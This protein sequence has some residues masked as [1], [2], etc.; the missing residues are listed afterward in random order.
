MPGRRRAVEALPGGLFAAMVL[1]IAAAAKGHPT[2]VTGV[3]AF[4]SETDTEAGKA[5]R[6][7]RTW[8]GIWVFTNAYHCLARMENGRRGLSRE[9][10]AKLS[11]DE[12]RRYFE[13]LGHFSSTAGMYSVTGPILRRRWLVAV[14]PELIG[15]E[16]V[17]TYAIAGD[18]LTVDLPRRS[19]ESGPSAR[20]VYRRVEGPDERPTP[21]TGVW[22]FV[23]ES[24]AATGTLRYDDM[25][26]DAIWIFTARHHCVARMQRNRQALSRADL[27]KLPAPEQVKYYEQL[28]RYAST[29]GEYTV[30]GRTLRRTWR[31]A[32]SPDLVGRESVATYRVDG[33]RL[34]VNLPSR[35]PAS[36]PE[37]RL[38]YR[39]LE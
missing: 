28:L 25:T 17:G 9:E 10:L 27:A 35:S 34:V 5:I 31:V 4:V 14:G 29:A 18:R 36:G 12:Q 6:D 23:S 3:W 19:P 13:Q 11:P 21:V 7:D 37:V 1:A 16:S 22:G 15:Q 38:V 20:V 24:D 33:D 2:P 39:R 32:N 26:T 30:E 8:T